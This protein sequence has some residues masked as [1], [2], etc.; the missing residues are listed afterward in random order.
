MESLRRDQV[1]VR[2]DRFSNSLEP[3]PN[4]PSDAS[5]LGV[6]HHDLQW[7]EENLQG[8]N[9]AFELIALADPIPKLKQADG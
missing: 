2:A 9:V 1:I 3:R 8:A 7:A 5:I 6:K 4:I